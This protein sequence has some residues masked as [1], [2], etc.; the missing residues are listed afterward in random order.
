MFSRPAGQFTLQFLCV[1][2]IAEVA[3][4]STASAFTHISQFLHTVRNFI[5][6]DALFFRVDH[7]LGRVQ[8][9]MKATL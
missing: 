5:N 3:D 9:S 7:I 2:I 4:A 8:N 1:C 6:M